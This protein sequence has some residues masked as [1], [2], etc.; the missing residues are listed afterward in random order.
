MGKG[1]VEKVKSKFEQYPNY[2]VYSNVKLN[3]FDPKLPDI[4]LLAIS[5]EPSLGFHV[6]VGEVKNNLPVV[7]G[8]D[9]L[10]AKG[11]K[12]FITKAIS[13]IETIK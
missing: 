1:L 11:V 4:D 2:K 5:Y 7:W 6:F 9:Y 10:K 13:Q 8:K 12:G 3:K